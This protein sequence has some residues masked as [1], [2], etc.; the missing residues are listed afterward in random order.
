MKFQLLILICA[1]VVTFGGCSGD[2]E[3]P[4]GEFEVFLLKDT[5]VRVHMYSET[6][7]NDL[8]LAD[9]PWI[10]ASDIL[11]YDWDAHEILFKKKA[12]SLLVQFRNVMSGPDIP[13]V[14]V[15]NG[16]RVYMGVF[17]WIASS[18]IGPQVPIMLARGEQAGVRFG[19]PRWLPSYDPR[20]DIRIRECLEEAGILVH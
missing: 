6:H 19:S 5:S 15:A 4:R 18:Y 12:A 14:V 10:T 16:E 8:S 13:F 9:S 20:N 17:P 3:I 11:S 2:P 1:F 7:L